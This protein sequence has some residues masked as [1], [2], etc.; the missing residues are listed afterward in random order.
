MSQ[1]LSFIWVYPGLCVLKHDKSMMCM[2]V[3]SL[4]LV[5][6]NNDDNNNNTGITPWCGEYICIVWMN[7]DENTRNVSVWPSCFSN[8]LINPLM[9]L[10]F[11]SFYIILVFQSQFYLP[12]LTPPSPL[13][14]AVPARCGDS[15]RH[16]LLTNTANA[17]LWGSRSSHQRSPGDCCQL[18]AVR[19]SLDKKE[20]IW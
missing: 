13:F 16:H 1:Y 20:I 12:S 9:L 8:M 2:D 15:C 5:H 7:H 3:F 6:N 19:S 10:Q 18:P 17:A 14:P 4:I 11:T